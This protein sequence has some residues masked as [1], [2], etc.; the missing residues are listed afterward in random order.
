MALCFF[1]K[2]GL[3]KDAFIET[4]A[5]SS[6]IIDLSCLI[7][8][9]ISFYTLKFTT[10]SKNTYGFVVGGVLAALIGSIIGNLTVK[11]LP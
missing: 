11:N 1:S 8:H 2:T 7:V 4:S 5:I 3:D 6:V 9:R 10:I